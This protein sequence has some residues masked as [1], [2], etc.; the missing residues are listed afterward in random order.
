M[1][2]LVWYGTMQNEAIT[3]HLAFL[4]LVQMIMAP[5]GLLVLTFLHANFQ[6]DRDKRFRVLE[7]IGR[8][9]V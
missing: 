3:G 8:A 1:R 6:K 2:V 7:Q 5:N 9:H 4:S